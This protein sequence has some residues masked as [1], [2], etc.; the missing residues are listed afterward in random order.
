MAPDLYIPLMAFMTFIMLAC[1]A[2]GVGQKFNPDLIGSYTVNCLFFAVLEMC[3]YKVILVLVR[4]QT[5]S[6]LDLMAFLNYKFVG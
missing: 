2:K 4:V 5:L 6:W 1:L 3:L